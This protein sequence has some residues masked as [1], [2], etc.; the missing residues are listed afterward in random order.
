MC[1]LCLGQETENFGVQYCFGVFFPQQ[2]SGVSLR[3]E[4][5]VQVSSVE[6]LVVSVLLHQS[7]S[8]IQDNL[9]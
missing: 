1:L 6:I 8:Q 5:L 7:D 2:T 4:V 3:Q 9:F